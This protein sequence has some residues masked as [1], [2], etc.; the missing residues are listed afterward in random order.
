MCAPFLGVLPWCYKIEARSAVTQT[1]KERGSTEKSDLASGLG[2]LGTSTGLES[3]VPELEPGLG[4]EPSELELGHQVTCASGSGAWAA[5]V[6]RDGRGNVKAGAGVKG[7]S[8][9]SW[10]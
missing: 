1:H 7:V 5:E 8:C 6:G 10:S 3:G 4:C 2:S 9:Q